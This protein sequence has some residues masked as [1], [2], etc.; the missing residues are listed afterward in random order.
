MSFDRTLTYLDRIDGARSEE[1][2]VRELL[3][4]TARFGF[5]HLLAGVVPT[6]KVTASVFRK[7]ILLSRWPMTWAAR[8][9]DRRYFEVDPVIRRLRASTP[10][11]IGMNAP[12]PIPAT[13][14]W[15][16]RRNS[17][18]L[19]LC[20]SLHDARRRNRGPELWRRESGPLVRGRFFSDDRVLLRDRPAYAASQGR[21]GRHRRAHHREGAG[22]S[23]IGPP[24][25][26]PS[27]RPQ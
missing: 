3:A 23:P 12:L 13:R 20:R 22:M 10:R 2:I 11:S 14:S 26:K 5:D 21:S 24:P 7:S 15:R 19:G 18:S 4:V 9:L 27:G 25:A 6:A 17:G 16:R 8:Y 1:E